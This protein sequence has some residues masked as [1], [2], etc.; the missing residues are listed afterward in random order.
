VS[1]DRTKKKKVIQHKLIHILFSPVY[2]RQIE[3]KI[4]GEREKERKKDIFAVVI[5]LN[6]R[7]NIRR[8]KRN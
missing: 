7:V 3:I 6:Q 1:F 5:L 4:E 8:E 2:V